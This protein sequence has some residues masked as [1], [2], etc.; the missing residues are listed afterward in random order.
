MPK[1]LKP[2]EEASVSCTF[3]CK[4]KLIIQSKKKAKSESK[5]ISEI[6][7]DFLKQYIKEEK[8]NEEK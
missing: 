1:L 3:S 8:Q 4:P 7:S 6:I 5:K 2:G